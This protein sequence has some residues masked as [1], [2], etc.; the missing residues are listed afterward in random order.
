MLADFDMR[1]RGDEAGEGDLYRNAAAMTRRQ[2]GAP[3]GLVRRQIQRRQQARCFVSMA[4]RN[5][6]GSLPAFFASSSMKL[7]MAKT[8]LLGPTPRQNPVGTAGGSS[9]TI[10][11]RRLGIA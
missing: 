10:S 4:R 2:L 9:R 8:L 5:S 1:H 6:T 3:S 7:S 11:T